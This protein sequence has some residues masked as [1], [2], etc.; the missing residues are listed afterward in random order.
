[1]RTGRDDIISSRVY[2][3]DIKFSLDGYKDSI[4]NVNYVDFLGVILSRDG[5]IVSVPY[6]VF[7]Q[8]NEKSP[9]GSV[10]KSS[11]PRD[12]R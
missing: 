8:K 1:M 9:Y 3:L 12:Y 4:H 5:Y 6:V 2:F 11:I 7:S 10:R